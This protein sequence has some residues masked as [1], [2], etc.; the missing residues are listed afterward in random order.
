MKG[1][2][3]TKKSPCKVTL[4]MARFALLGLVLSWP[5]NSPASGKIVI[6][7]LLTTGVGYESNYFLDEDSERAVNNIYIRPGIEFGY[8]TGKSNI[9][10]NYLLDANWYDESDEP[11]EGEADLDEFDYV[12]HDMEFSADSQVSDRLKVAVEDNYILT[13]DPDQLDYYSNE[14][15]R[16]KYG[17]NI[18]KPHLLYTFGEKFSLGVAY[19]YTDINY[20]ND[21]EED[22][23][24][25]RGGATLKYRLDGLNSLDLDYQYWQKD[26]E[27]VDSDYNSNQ[28]TLRF[29]RELKYYTLSANGGYHLRSFDDDLRDDTD[30]FIWGLSI[31]GTRPQMLFALTQNLND[32]A[33]NND[34]YLATRFIGE[35]GH[36][37]IEKINVN[38]KSYYQ[39]SDYLESIDDREDHTWSLSLE[40]DYQRNE[41]L[42][43]FIEPGYSSRDSSVTGNDYENL[44]I[45][46][47]INI[48]YNLGAR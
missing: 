26:Y 32:T 19:T 6:K 22:S 10:F 17:K 21:I 1:K 2:Y 4:Y 15:I 24:E 16:N 11:P 36:L 13:R 35:I 40:V 46:A 38:L 3:M 5:I 18:L 14:V 45:F 41:Y 29:N 33:L 9:L 47:G 42:S 34:Y 44:Y 31:S 12:G 30:D 8:T 7:P 43:F 28:L 27:Q 39:F 20:E 23:K 37:F 25:N 48:N